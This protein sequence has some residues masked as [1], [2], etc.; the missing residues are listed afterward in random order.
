[1][2]PRKTYELQTTN[3]KRTKATITETNTS[4]PLFEL[5]LGFITGDIKRSEGKH[6]IIMQTPSTGASMPAHTVGVCDIQFSSLSKPIHIGFGDPENAPNDVVWQDLLVTKK[7]TAGNVAIGSA[8]GLELNIDL[9]E[10]V[11]Q[12]SFFWKRT[13]E[14]EGVSAIGGKMDWLHLKMVEKESD[15]A[16]AYFKH[17]FLFGSKRGTFILEEFDGGNEWEKIVMLSGC[18]VLEYMRKMTG[19]SW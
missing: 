15:K 10:G 14:I 12:R 11:G 7:L 5:D 19:W 17:N 18:A 13:S 3:K 9:G 2:A 1:M 16:V 6:S 4:Q 8:G